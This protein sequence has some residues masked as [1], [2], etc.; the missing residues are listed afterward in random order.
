MREH[1]RYSF[2]LFKETAISGG[3]KTGDKIPIITGEKIPTP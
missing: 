2:P 1:F 3:V